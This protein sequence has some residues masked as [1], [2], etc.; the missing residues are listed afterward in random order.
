MSMFDL[1]EQQSKAILD[2]RLQK[3][4]ALEVNKLKK[5][6]DELMTLIKSLKDLLSNKEMRMSLIKEELVEIKE[7][8]GDKEELRL[9]ILV[10][11]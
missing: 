10:V 11:T 3:L 6:H 5:E 2:L 8:Y 4:T 9:I 1:S 7:R